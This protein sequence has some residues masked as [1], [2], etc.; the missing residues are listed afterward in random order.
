MEPVYLFFAEGTEEVEA[1][2]VVD[3]LRRAGVETHIVSVSG[4]RT[5]AGAHG[6]RVEADMMAEDVDFSKAAMLVL[7]GGLPGAYNLADC[8][9]LTDGIRTH[10]ASGKP[11]AAIC[12][13]PL[14]Y[15]RMGLLKGLKATC[16]PG[17]ENQ[18]EGA[19]Y[20]ASL[21]EEDGQFITG[22]GPAAVFAFGYA[23]ATRLAGR[24]KAES[25]KNGMLYNELE[26]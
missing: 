9:L 18:L 1:L 16:Y 8:K 4:G 5:V 10:H 2:A 3:I 22:K 11:L 7:P 26:K 23:I 24:E 21:V 17:F 19:E 14:V 15:G 6:I 20:T 25:V 12:A 13:A